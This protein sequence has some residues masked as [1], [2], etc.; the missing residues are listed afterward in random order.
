MPGSRVGPGFT[1]SMCSDLFEMSG[2]NLCVKSNVEEEASAAQLCLM[3]SYKDR[4]SNSV[5]SNKC[6]PAE[7]ILLQS[8]NFQLKQIVVLGIYV[9][10][11][12]HLCEYLVARSQ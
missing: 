5:S 2:G 1:T 8:K 4:L 11:K 10:E 6:S 7:E 3:V 9:V 12:T